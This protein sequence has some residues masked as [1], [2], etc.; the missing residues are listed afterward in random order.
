MRALMDVKSDARPGVR[1][2]SLLDVSW[3]KASGPNPTVYVSDIGSC[4]ARLAST[5]SIST[6]QASQSF[7]LSGKAT[8]TRFARSCCTEIR[9]SY[10]TLSR[11]PTGPVGMRNTTTV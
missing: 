9:C 7:Q 4:N 1:V 11:R 6:L 3:L 5:F 10:R 8:L 2:H